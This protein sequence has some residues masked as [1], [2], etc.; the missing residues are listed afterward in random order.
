MPLMC[1]M[2]MGSVIAAFIKLSVFFLMVSVT[3]AYIKL[4]V[5]CF[6]GFVYCGREVVCIMFQTFSALRCRCIC[7]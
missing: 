7:H 6:D 1:R 3:A 2:L 4:S 5:F